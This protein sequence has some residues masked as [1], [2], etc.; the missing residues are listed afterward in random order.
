MSSIDMA[1]LDADEIETLNYEIQNFT[2]KIKDLT[3]KIDCNES[4]MD[5]LYSEIDSIKA[6]EAPL[7]EL[8]FKKIKIQKRIDALEERLENMDQLDPMF[9]ELVSN[10]IE[11]EKNIIRNKTQKNK[12]KMI[13]V[14]TQERYDALVHKTCD[15]EANR[16]ICKRRRNR[17]YIRLGQKPLEF[18]G[19]EDDGSSSEMEDDEIDS[20]IEDD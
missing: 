6:P 2:S 8:K 19:M 14:Q 7:D 17:R 12:I 5:I 4:K 3:S 13:L 16:E 11:L 20:E 18:D 1:F 10:V 9:A 15:L